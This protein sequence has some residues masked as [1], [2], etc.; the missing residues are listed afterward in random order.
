MRISKKCKILTKFFHHISLGDFKTAA[1]FFIF[2]GETGFWCVTLFWVVVWVCKRNW[3]K[4]FF[5]LEIPPHVLN[6]LD[7]IPRKIGLMCIFI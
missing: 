3:A 4:N 1:I 7:L 5:P 2:E 6:K